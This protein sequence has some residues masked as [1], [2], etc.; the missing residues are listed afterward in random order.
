MRPQG[1]WQETSA[2]QPPC[3]ISDHLPPRPRQV[4]PKGAGR[5]GHWK[6]P[7][8]I[9]K[10]DIIADVS[11]KGN[12]AEKVL[13]YSNELIDTCLDGHEMNEVWKQII[14]KYNL[15]VTIMNTKENLSEQ[16]IDEFHE[17]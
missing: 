2:N 7:I 9:D 11:F 4:M 6:I 16:K 1:L 15:L 13:Q 12:R 17:I 10:N 8:T 5:L 3:G 14:T